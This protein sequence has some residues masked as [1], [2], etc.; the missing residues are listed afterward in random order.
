MASRFLVTFLITLL[1]CGAAIVDRPAAWHNAIHTFGEEGGTAT[2]VRLRLG[3]PSLARSIGPAD[4]PPLERRGARHCI[5][6][7]DK[8]PQ[9]AWFYTIPSAGYWIVF[10][11]DRVRC[12]FLGPRLVQALA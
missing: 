11:G 5:A 8:A 7:P 9:T 1:C 12:D 2:L 6:P 3:K 4:Y 10:T